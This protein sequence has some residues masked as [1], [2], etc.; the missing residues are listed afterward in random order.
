MSC[1]CHKYNIFA[2][3]RSRVSAATSLITAAVTQGIDFLGQGSRSTAFELKRHYFFFPRIQS[4]PV[5]LIRECCWPAIRESTRRK[6]ER[7]LSRDPR[8]ARCCLIH[9]Q[10]SEPD[11]AVS[12]DPD[13][14]RDC[15]CVFMSYTGRVWGLVDACVDILVLHE[16]NVSDRQTKRLIFNLLR[17]FH[18]GAVKQFLSVY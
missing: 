9:L 12:H 8:P 10:S 16:G 11:A 1:R 6:R 3:L 13:H 5:F 4:L 7:A 2:Q 15:T 18:N 14:M 17:L